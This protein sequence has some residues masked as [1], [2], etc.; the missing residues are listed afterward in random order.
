MKTLLSTL[1]VL[2]AASLS[3]QLQ[4]SPIYPNC[5]AG[6]LASYE[7]G[8]ANDSSCA[9]GGT[10]GGVEIIDGFLYSGP[11]GADTQIQLVP[12]QVG[13]GGGFTYSVFPGA[14][15]GQTLTFDIAFF[16]TIDSGPIGSGANLGMD[17]G[18]VNITESICVDSFF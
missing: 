4:A 1:T 5:V 14:D 16:Y 8:G 9:I 11:A 2:L 18:N 10:T 3:S 7:P 12:D 15:P 17:P 13:L 6:S